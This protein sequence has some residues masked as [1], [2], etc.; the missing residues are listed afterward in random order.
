MKRRNGEPVSAEIV[1]QMAYFEQHEDRKID[2][3]DMPE[4]T[5]W[6]SAVQGKFFKPIKQ[7]LSLRLDAD[8]VAWFKASGEGY[9]TRIND[10]LREYVTARRPMSKG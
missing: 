2:L 6:S 5:D 1:A 9:Q 10:A 7:P 4:V 3:T 8:L